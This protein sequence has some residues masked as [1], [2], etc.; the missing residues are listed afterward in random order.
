MTP[1]LNSQF[2]L[3][4]NLTADTQIHQNENGTRVLFDMSINHT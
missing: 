1:N 4:G 3:L 2:Q